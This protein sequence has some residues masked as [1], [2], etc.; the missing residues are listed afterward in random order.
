MPGVGEGKILVKKSDNPFTRRARVFMGPTDWSG[1]TIEVDARA[2][3]KGRQ[4]GSVGVIAQRY[5]L[6]LAG[7]TQKVELQSWQP[8][9][10]RTAKA[11]FRWEPD[12]WYRLKLEVVKEDGGKVVARGKVWPRGEAEPSA[13]LI[14]RR[15][16]SP[17]LSGSVGIYADAQPVEVFFDNLEVRESE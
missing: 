3:R 16:A 13:W 1:Y 4:I 5:Q 15:D 8:E 14:E 11:D 6:T 7:N 9:T 12:K 2:T 17:N 10:T